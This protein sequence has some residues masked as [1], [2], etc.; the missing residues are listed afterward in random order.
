[1]SLGVLIV[2]FIMVFSHESECQNVY[3]PWALC[4]SIISLVAIP[5]I[6]WKKVLNDRKDFLMAKYAILEIIE[7]EDH[8]EAEEFHS[9][10]SKKET[11]KL[12]E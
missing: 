10:A 2:T 8:I 11:E 5:N 9:D 12:I 4:N 1:M 6:Y 3:K 7:K